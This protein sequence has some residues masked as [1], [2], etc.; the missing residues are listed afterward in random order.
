MDQP[1]KLVVHDMFCRFLWCL[2]LSVENDY[3]DITHLGYS[4]LLVIFVTF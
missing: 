2:W 3:L 1:T 4:H